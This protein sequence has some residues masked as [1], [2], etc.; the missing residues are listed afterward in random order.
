MRFSF[1]VGNVVEIL[2]IYKYLKTH[3]PNQSDVI[4]IENF[5]GRFN[6]LYLTPYMPIFLRQDWQLA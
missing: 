5:L 3:L 4:Y 2:G 6:L 1:I